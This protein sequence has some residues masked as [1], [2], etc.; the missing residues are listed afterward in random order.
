MPCIKKIDEFDTWTKEPY[1]IFEMG[2]Y[3][4]IN[5][6]INY[7]GIWNYCLHEEFEQHLIFESTFKLTT[8]QL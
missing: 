2:I 5:E 6:L 8:D 7:S 4:S 3:T 1:L